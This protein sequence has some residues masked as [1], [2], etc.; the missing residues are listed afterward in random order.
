MQ[1]QD[2][3][4][5]LYARLENGHQVMQL[6]VAATKMSCKSC[7]SAKVG[8]RLAKFA[9]N[10]MPAIAQ[11]RCLQECVM[12]AGSQT[13]HTSPAD[14][15]DQ[16]SADL[17]NLCTQPEG[18]PG[19]AEPIVDETR[20]ADT[21]MDEAGTSEED[22]AAANATDPTGASERARTRDVM[23]AK[24]QPGLH[25]H[26]GRG[27]FAARHTV[28]V[29]TSA[30]PYSKVSFLLSMWSESF[31]TYIPA[32]Q[33]A[34]EG[35][36]FLT[37]GRV[38]ARYTA[39]DVPATD[40]HSL[41][42]PAR[43]QCFKDT[44]LDYNVD[45]H[46][47]LC[48]D[49]WETD[50]IAPSKHIGQLKVRVK[51]GQAASKSG[52]GHGRPAS[53]QQQDWLDMLAVTSANMLVYGEAGSGKSHIVKGPLRC[54]LN[55]LHGAN[56]VWITASTAL[57]ALGIDGTTIHAQAGLQRGRGTAKEIV[58]R[59]KVPVRRRWHLV[60]V[61]VIEECSMLSAAFF[62]LLDEVARSMKSASKQP[63][64]GLQV[65]LVGD[66]QQLP[67]VP[68]YVQQANKDGKEVFKQEPVQYLFQSEAW[69]Q[70]DF[71]C[72]KLAHC[73]RYVAL[74]RLGTLLRSLRTRGKL[75]DQVHELRHLMSGAAI[76]EDALDTVVL[77]CKKKE[78]RAYSHTMLAKLPGG[79]TYYTAVDSH[80]L[81]QW[82][83]SVD[84][85]ED[86]S[87]DLAN[88]SRRTYC[89]GKDRPKS[90][91]SSFPVPAVLR[92]RVGAK[93]LCKTN[94]G[95][96][97][98]NGTIG[99]VVELVSMP[100]GDALLEGSRLGFHANDKQV[101]QDWDKVNADKKWPVVKFVVKDKT[102]YKTV[103]P[104]RLTIEDSIG[105]V[106]CARIQ[107]PLLLCYALTVHSAQGMTLRHVIFKIQHIF[108]VGQLYSGLSRAED[109]ENIQVVGDVNENMLCAALEVIAFEQNTQWCLID[110][111]LGSE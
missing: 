101:Q 35:I 16:Q 76:K 51:F 14:I 69:S 53:M 45:K 65:I 10:R 79:D 90:L 103:V 105:Q 62:D 109:F 40:W 5:L 33:K 60:K 46:I 104:R 36:K 4:L 58:T 9:V 23:A 63:F 70:G 6:Q 24:G 49:D 47:F 30:Q 91:F 19:D 39:Q 73:W 71:M 111:G 48:K 96:G 31:T 12:V 50:F 82:V 8:V 64:G 83:N 85:E 28:H 94:M 89:D 106:L 22:E 43:L 92:L 97:V 110:N 18:L 95:D 17:I 98:V 66:F 3:Q 57:A 7:A 1:D 29:I 44:V 102:C 56:S 72:F 20:I 81:K 42:L 54:A 27:R 13:A 38:A 59:M 37:D 55:A 11:S 100:L 86:D 2:K 68:D 75:G 74:G 61:V 87:F 93:V 32:A 108:S 67:P 52:T 80:G 41:D 15:Y 34:N 84:D 25:Y 21:R 77:C 26:R 99:T 88:D 107:L 78:A